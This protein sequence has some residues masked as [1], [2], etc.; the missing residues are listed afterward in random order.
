VKA[1]GYYFCE[2]C[3]ENAHS[4]RCQKCHGEATFKTVEAE[5]LPAPQPAWTPPEE[6]ELPPEPPKPAEPKISGA[7][8]IRRMREIV[9][10]APDTL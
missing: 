5:I 6:P 8:W 7:E 10:Q 4:I 3:E 9:A 2:K 1:H